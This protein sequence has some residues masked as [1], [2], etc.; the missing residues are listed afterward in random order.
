MKMKRMLSAFLVAVMMI[1]LAVTAIPVFAAEVTGESRATTTPLKT[2]VVNW[3]QLIDQGTMRSQWA[4]DRSPRNNNMEERYKVTATEDGAISFEP[5]NDG[6]ARLYYSDYMFDITADTQYVYEFEVKEGFGDPDGGVIYAFAANPNAPMNV[7]AHEITDTYGNQITV[8]ESAY[9]IMAGTNSYGYQMEIHYGRSNRKYGGDDTTKHAEVDGAYATTFTDVKITGGYVKYKVVYNGLDV[10]I[11]YL[12][13][14]DQYVEIFP[15]KD[16]SLP[17]GA[18]LAFGISAWN[19]SWVNLKNCKIYAMNQAAADKM[20]VQ[21][22]DKSAFIAALDEADKLVENEYTADSWAAFKAALE[23]VKTHKKGATT[24]AAIDAAMTALTEAKALLESALTSDKLALKAIIAEANGI[25]A[26]ADYATKYT[27]TSRNKLAKAIEDAKAIFDGADIFVADEAEAVAALRSAINGLVDVNLTAL[28]GYNVNWKFFVDTRSTEDQWNANIRN[29]MYNLYNITGTMGGLE[30][31]QKGGET[32]AYYSKNMFAITPNTYYE[33]EFLARNNPKKPNDTAGVVFAYNESTDL[34]Y[35]MYGVFQNKTTDGKATIGLR[36]GHQ[37]PGKYLWSNSSA[38]PVVKEYTDDAG[39]KYGKYKVVYNGYLLSFYYE[40]AEGVWTQLFTDAYGNTDPIMLAVGSKVAF[41]IYV[42]GDPFTIIKDCKLSAINA[43]AASI[44]AKESL[45]F[46]ISVANDKKAGT[47]TPAT[48]AAMDAKLTAAKNAYNATSFNNTSA[49]AARDALINA[50]LALV[51]RADKT[52]LQAKYDEYIK[53]NAADWNGETDTVWKMFANTLVKAK[54]LLDDANA[55]QA[56]VNAMVD[57]LDTKREALRPTPGVTPDEPGTEDPGT[58]DP[59]TDDATGDSTG[60]ATGDSTGDSTGDAT[61]D[62]TGDA[63]GDSTGDATGD[64]T[65]N[66][67]GDATGDSIG[68]ATGDATGDLTGNATDDATDDE[69]RGDIF[70]T[71][72]NGWGGIDT[73][74]NGSESETKKSNKKDKDD[75]DDDEQDFLGE[76][77]LN[78]GC[79]SAVSLSALL[80]VGIIGGAVVLKKKDD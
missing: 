51:K 75:D 25:V 64:S 1:S 5:I 18:K 3:K 13:T 2:Y 56:D 28:Y 61:G 9:H 53:L 76:L 44:I 66:A 58:E 6:D 65:G 62:S 7:V 71:D 16:F 54:A 36:Y 14:S 79:E 48:V 63:T 19:P 42:Q 57:S 73:D 49:D 23:T 12:N 41:G 74:E 8:P 29:D 40:S 30:V 32:R 70:D 35:F 45:A 31:S 21:P 27:E 10:Q 68:D 24:Q 55:S 20:N 69:T 11:Y 80:V 50:I 26:G 77:D 78:F 37:D 38:Y 34:A 15:D 47:Y 22:Y 4:Y 39:N 17:E 46:A 67:T 72:E 52:V 60:D 33:Y 59:G 43:E